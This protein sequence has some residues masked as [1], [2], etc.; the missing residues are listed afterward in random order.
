ME[1]PGQSHA[2]GRAQASERGRETAGRGRLAPQER[3]AHQRQGRSSS[4]PSSCWCSPTSSAS[5][6]PSRRRWSGSGVKASR[7][8]RR[9]LAVSAPP[10][11]LR[12]RH[13]RRK[14]PP[15]A[16]A[17]Q[18]AA[19]FLGLGR[20]RQGRQP[21]RHRHQEPGDRQARS[22]GSSWPRIARSWWPRRERSTACCCGTTTSFRSGT[23]RSSAWRGGTCSG[24]R[25]SCR[26]ARPSFLRVWW[27]DDAAAKRLA[28]GRG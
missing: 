22:T 24:V 21:Q 25:P 20:R 28:D 9:H 19:R 12:L 11:H 17:R 3:R 6:C 4:P 14:L 10:R 26:R 5:C 8:H 16:F 7:A 27:Y 1:E 15:V 18:R 13:H 23:C 2:R